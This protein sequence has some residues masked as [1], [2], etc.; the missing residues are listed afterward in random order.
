MPE[1]KG[2]QDKGLF[3]SVGS[4]FVS[5]FGL[6]IVSRLL[7]FILNVAIA[8]NVDRTAY[9]QGAVQLQLVS[10][11]ILM[12]SRE[13]FRDALQRTPA[14]DWHDEG[15]RARMLRVASLS[16]P[17]SLLVAVVVLG[18]GALSGGTST[19]GPEVR[20]PAVLFALA[21]T[22]EMAAEPLYIMAH[23]LLLI[24]IRVWVEMAALSVR[25]GVV[26]CSVWLW[27]QAPLMAFA[28]G[29]LAYG[30][31]IL[32]CLAAYFSLSKE[33]GGG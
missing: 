13:G 7:T 31:T 9:G 28:G 17:F 21:A 3:K 27:P 4:G 29:Q 30:A 2:G 12:L 19:S 33:H 32:V 18:T 23:N 6:Q 8:R 11:A 22:V 20:V 15:K 16:L 26:A 14:A 1:D 10:D 5:L 25:V 24:R